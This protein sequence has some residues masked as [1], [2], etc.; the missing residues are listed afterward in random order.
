MQI[1]VDSQRAVENRRIFIVD[2]DEVNS[3]GLQ[4]I[5]ADEYETHIL[6]G[7][8]AAISKAQHWPPD[9]VLLGTSHI[10]QD[11][12]ATISR[13][14]A[15]LPQAKILLVCA[16]ADQPG[17]NEALAAGANGLLTAPPTIEGARRRVNTALGRIAP[18]GIPVVPV[19]S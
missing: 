3:M 5:L 7:P 12:T 1:G 2:Q 19:Q 15:Q 13:L 16:N 17:V 10:A 8:D 14:R 4:F 11:A 6:A 18:L 9:L